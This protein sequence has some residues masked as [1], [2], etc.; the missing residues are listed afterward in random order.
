[1]KSLNVEFLKDYVFSI[2]SVPY[3]KKKGDSAKICEVTAQLL[4]KRKVCKI[5]KAKAK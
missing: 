5:I 1:M 3:D 2:D 4:C